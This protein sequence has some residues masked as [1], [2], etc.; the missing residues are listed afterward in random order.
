MTRENWTDKEF[1]ED[2]T[3][4]TQEEYDALKIDREKPIDIVLY[5]MAMTWEVE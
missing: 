5:P 1:L 4:I 3:F 2:A